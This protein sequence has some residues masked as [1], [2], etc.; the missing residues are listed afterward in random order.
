MLGL[1]HSGHQ[2]SALNVETSRSFQYGLWAYS[3]D[4]WIW[5]VEHQSGSKSNSLHLANDATK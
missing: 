2:L 4:R 5:W 3:T 1:Y